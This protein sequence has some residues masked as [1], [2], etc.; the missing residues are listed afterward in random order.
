MAQPVPTT[1]LPASSRSAYQFPVYKW[2]GWLSVAGYAIGLTVMF[3]IAGMFGIPAPLGWAALVIMLTAGA[4][5]LDRPKLLLACTM[6]YFMFLPRNRLLGLLGLPLPGFIDEVFFLPFIAVIVMNWIQRRQLREATVFPVVFFLISALSWYVNGR[7]SVFTAIQ[8]TL[9][10]L[11]S[12]ILWYYCRLT[13]TFENNRQLS[14]WVWIYIIYAAVQYIYNI[15]WQ[16]GMWP[17]YHPDASGGMLGPDGAGN[18][19]LVGYISMFAI[20]LLAGWWIS[21]GAKASK[22][23]RFWALVCLVVIAYD[24]IFMTD[25]KHAL[26]LF[27]V[28]AIPILLHPRFPARLRLGLLTAGVL[29][30]IV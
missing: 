26:L 23:K 24:F 5:L 14:R 6:F 19:H 28:T 17:R 12:Y 11:K 9:I 10:M 15:I 8:V 21:A 29:F 1:T 27:P 18:A 25:T 13:S 16:K 2:I 7:G 4:M 3:F 22:Q 20:F 30:M